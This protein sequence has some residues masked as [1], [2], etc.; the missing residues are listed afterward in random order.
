MS[1]SSTAFAHLRID[2]LSKSFPDRRVFTNISFSVPY[3]DRVGII[4]ENGSGKTTLLR[5]L[6]GELAPDAGVIETFTVHGD[7]MHIGLLRQEPQFPDHLSVAEL[8]EASVS[9]L[10]T[11]EIEL[12]ETAQALAASPENPK[13]LDRYAA[14]LEAAERLGVWDIEARIEAT[15]HGLG[16]EELG[17]D[18]PLAQL[19]GGQRARLAMASLLLSTPDVLL[20]D[21]PTNHLDDRAIEYLAHVITTWH[22]PVV[23]VSHDRAF[24]DATVVSI[25]DLDP[26]PQPHARNDADE[27]LHTIGATR[28]TGTYT[29]YLRAQ[30]EARQ[31]W[32]HQYDREQAELKRL[33][34]AVQ[35]NQMVGHSDWKPRTESRI[36]K[37]FYGDRNAKVVARRVNDAR[38]RLQTL[39]QHQIA[40]PP[41]PLRFHGLDAAGQPE[42][43]RRSSAET[44]I[45]LHH[46]SVRGRL[47]PV[48]VTIRAL[49]KLLITGANGIGKSTLL[50]L[51]AGQLQPTRGRIERL[52]DLQVGILA[53]ESPFDKLTHH[54]ARSLYEHFVG[55]AHAATVPLS[56]FGLLSPRD[57]NRPVSRLSTGQQR[58]LALAILLAN[59]PEVLLLDEP[60]NHLALALVTELEASMHDYPGAVVVASHDRW[61][62]DRW[63]GRHLH[64]ECDPADNVDLG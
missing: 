6:A 12:D 23:I 1:H 39:E 43:P 42:A 8:L 16:L 63:Q 54:T 29:D 46:A 48:S 10:R 52:E 40:K 34:A 47:A 4:G 14:A 44:V 64:I 53:Q 7:P 11:A 57:E 26:A 36:A 45:R 21:E 15:M 27:P 22:G 13:V 62:R 56:T 32:Q 2:G 17:R 9:R 51:L 49:D 33:R 25:L 24:L 19:S 3:H 28:F 38:S 61:L 58:R 35:D 50:Q 30:H 55:A 60:T 59:P 18:Q 31:R 20:L 37:K 41:Q 5:I